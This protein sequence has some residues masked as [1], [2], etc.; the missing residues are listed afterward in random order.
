MENQVIVL[1]SSPASR[2]NESFKRNPCRT[3]LPSFRQK[4]DDVYHL[5]FDSMRGSA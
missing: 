4:A 5:L 2:E 3:T 1:P